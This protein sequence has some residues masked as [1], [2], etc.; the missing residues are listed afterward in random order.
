MNINRVFYSLQG[1]GIHTGLP[2]NFIRLQGCNL[3]PDF[4]CNYCD[5]KLAQAPVTRK[6]I[7]L[8]I[9]S[10][11]EVSREQRRKS[12]CN[13]CWWYCITG[14]EP[15]FQLEELGELVKEI[16]GRDANTY[17][18]EIETNGTLP[19]PNWFSV[20]DSWVVDVKGPSAGKASCKVRFN[21][22]LPY[23]RRCDQVKFVV[24]NLLDLEFVQKILSEIYF[25]SHILISPIFLPNIAFLPEAINFVKRYNLRLSPQ[26]H[27]F[28]GVE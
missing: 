3:Y 21:E 2:M 20:I 1:E 25:P 19:P 16:K 27:R 9:E 13:V 23:L 22:W 15:L 28:I 5:T 17:R 6:S 8:D 10:I 18:I 12:D 4:C 24:G 26:Y 14:G 11:L 7:D